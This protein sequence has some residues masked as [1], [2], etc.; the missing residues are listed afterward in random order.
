M[1]FSE[2]YKINSSNKE[3]SV[4]HLL[5]ICKCMYI[6]VCMYIAC[7][8]L[9]RLIESYYIYDWYILYIFLKSEEYTI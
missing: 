3:S 6:C 4:V 1:V 8:N 5:H 2:K 9:R 7:V